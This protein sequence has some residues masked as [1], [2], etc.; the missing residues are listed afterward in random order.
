MQHNEYDIGAA[1][2]AIEDELI[3]SM[4]RNMDRH[5]AEETKEGIEWSMWQAEQLKALEKY[6]RENRKRYG[7]LFRNLNNEMGEL[8]RM[9]RQ[10]GNM[11]QEIQILNAI[12]KGFPARKISKGATAEFFK[13]N[14]RKLEALI[15]A[16]THDME[17]AETA[18][19]RKAN[20]DY[21]KAIFNAQVYANTG[22]GTYEK[23]VDMATRDMLSRGLNCVEYANG[24]RHTLADYA[25]MAIRT[26]SKRAYLQGEGEKRQEWGITTVIV[27]KRGN[28]CPKCLPFVGKVLIDD[29]WSGGKKSDGLYPLMSQAIAAGLYH[30]R[31]KDSHTT[32]FPGISTADDT[33]TKE[34]LDA[35]ERANQKE[36]KRQYAERQAEKFRRLVAYSLDKENQERYM[37][38][39]EEWGTI[40]KDTEPDI[41]KPI[42]T[43][44]EIQVHPVGKIDKEIYKCIT[45]DIVTDEVIIT[46]ERIGHIKERHPNDYEKYCEYLKLIVEEPDYIVET[47]KPNTALILKEIKESNERQFKTVL[48]LTTSTD[49]PGFKNS[50]IT[51]MKIDEK[52]WNRLLRNKLILYKKE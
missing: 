31:C 15:E 41:I 42:D 51:F 8:I 27:N 17:A 10:R 14:D 13:L 2:Q 37:A 29:V 38:K 9:S 39:R 20:D 45:E 28:P 5:R 40:A 11:Q 34:E 30:P 7:K 19:L 4:I 46:D 48:R 43:E 26:A 18:V 52:E 21:R 44:E 50:I 16:T 32:Y 33:W 47:K 3:K 1:F 35:V 12:R 6:K 36:T 24:A 25:D 22:A 49:N 23:A